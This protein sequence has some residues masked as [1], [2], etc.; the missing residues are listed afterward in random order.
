M[1]TDSIHPIP[2]NT[3]KHSKE[4]VYLHMSTMLH[5]PQSRHCFATGLL[6]SPTS[7]R[8]R[9]SKLECSPRARQK[10]SWS[11]TGKGIPLTSLGHRKTG[12]I[13]EFLPALKHIK[14]WEFSVPLFQTN[15]NHTGSLGHTGSS[16][17]YWIESLEEGDACL[18]LNSDP[19]TRFI[20]RFFQTQTH[21]V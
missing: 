4:Q 10:S 14:T 13:W 1:A 8:C 9:F 12:R 5:P 6:P 20:Q 18:G 21:K 7:A 16:A 11:R 3:T 2:K 15:P 17:W 19:I